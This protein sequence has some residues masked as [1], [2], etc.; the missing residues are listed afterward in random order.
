VYTSFLASDGQKFS[1][2]T[3]FVS[4]QLPL[5]QGAPAGP[6]FY[7]G[8]TP[9]ATY[10]SH[11]EGALKMVSREVKYAGRM[12]FADGRLFAIDRLNP[13]L[14]D[15]QLRVITP[16]GPPVS[17]NFATI[18]APRGLTHLTRIEGRQ[19]IAIN[20][21]VQGRIFYLSTQP[22]HALLSVLQVEEDASDMAVFG[23]CLVVTSANP[24]IV[25][26][27]DH[28]DL[29]HPKVIMRWDVGKAGGGENLRQPTEVEVNPET[30]MVFLRSNHVCTECG[31]SSQ[32][33]VWSV[34]DTTGEM[35]KRCR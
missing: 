15:E 35:T 1:L 34:E 7:F 21:R 30:G 12:L 11:N 9:G 13:G 29:A 32:S 3:K 10:A 33:S 18:E 4:Y 28:Q 24:Q 25:S 27:V 22:P 16:G 19:A 5:D 8:T 6:D 14:G 31:G 2:K 26:I 20:E 17:T 23:H